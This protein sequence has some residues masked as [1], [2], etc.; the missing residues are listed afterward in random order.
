MKETYKRMVLKYVVP[1]II[2]K[3]LSWSGRSD[4]LQHD[5]ASPHASVTS[6]N[7]DALAETR[8]WGIAVR[9]QPPQSPDLNVLDLGFFASLQAEHFK[10]RTV[11]I[12][13][14]V[15]KVREA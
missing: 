6:A 10:Q 11:S 12:E 14:V 2:A 15:D 8:A 1:A 13:E 5:N 3:W 9:C 7:F 4:V